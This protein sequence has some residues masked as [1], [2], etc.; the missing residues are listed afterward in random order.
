MK[1]YMRDAPAIGEA[2]ALNTTLT[3]LDLGENDVGEEGGRA[4]GQAR[5]ASTPPSRSSIFFTLG[6][7]LG[8]GGR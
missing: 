8:E 1:T 6:W 3:Q 2:L 5:W 7:G 4:I